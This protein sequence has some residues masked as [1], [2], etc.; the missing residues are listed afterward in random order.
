MTIVLRPANPP[1]HGLLPS[2]QPPSEPPP[3]QGA[4]PLSEQPPYVGG[5][6]RR[7]AG[8]RPAQTHNNPP[9][10]PNH[11][12]TPKLQPTQ[13]PQDLPTEHPY[14][15]H[16]DMTQD[17]LRWLHEQRPELLPNFNPEDPDTAPDLEDPAIFTPLYLG[18][19]EHLAANADSDH[20][21]LSALY[22]LAE[23]RGYAK[24][25]GRLL[26]LAN[27]TIAHRIK[28]T[29]VYLLAQALGMI[30]ERLA[31]AQ[32]N[33]GGGL[34]TVP[35]PTPPGPRAPAPRL[36][37]LPWP[38]PPIP[39]QRCSRKRRP[40]PAPAPAAETANPTPAPKPNYDNFRRSILRDLGRLPPEP[41]PTL[42]DLLQRP[43]DPPLHPAG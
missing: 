1:T 21:R 10:P 5:P 43:R 18:A 22:L 39:R 16:H 42:L 15:Y 23:R 9:N 8:G 2:E 37:P 14:A 17:H 6:P 26:K 30:I 38:N 33:A 12:Q 27:T 4:C 36:P 32:I 3:T 35:L 25:K 28:L 34:P 20:D 19:L 31:E 40:K 11:R 13:H 41:Q 29:A 7:A 24:V